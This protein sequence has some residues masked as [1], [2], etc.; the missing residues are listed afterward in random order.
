MNKASTKVNPSIPMSQFQNFK[1]FNERRSK[2]F[3]MTPDYSHYHK[4]ILR[5]GNKIS[6]TNTDAMFNVTLPNDFFNSAVLNVE[7]FVA[8][9][10]VDLT[11]TSY[12][13]HIPQLLQPKSYDTITN[14][15]SD[16]VL[17]NIG[18]SFQNPATTSSLGVPITDPSF[19]N[20]KMLNVRFK[21]TAG[22]LA[23]IGDWIMVLTIYEVSNDEI[24]A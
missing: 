5:S 8:N 19:F 17:V 6:G 12:S 21:D 14:N 22:N 16:V 15:L 24:S 18:Q 13:I 3:K 20:H 2:P 10:S 7:T 1:E 11:D 23:S 4:I 9:G